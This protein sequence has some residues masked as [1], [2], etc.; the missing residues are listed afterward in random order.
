[1]VRKKLFN[2]YFSGSLPSCLNFKEEHTQLNF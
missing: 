2:T 1:M